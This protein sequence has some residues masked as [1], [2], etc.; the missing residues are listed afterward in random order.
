MIRKHNLMKAI[1][2][3]EYGSPNVLQ[4]KEVEK[5]TPG[6]DELLIKVHAVSVNRS[7]WEG[8]IGKPLYA[9]MGGLR[10]PGN[11][12]L[13]SDVAGHVE[14]VGKNNREFQPGDEVFGEMEGYHSGFAEYV[15][16]RGKAWALKPVSMTFEQASAIPQAGVIALQGIRDKGQ[17]QPGQ[18]VLINGAGGG[19]GTF[20]IQLAKLYGAEV[21]GVDN[22]GKLD[23]MRSLGTDHVIDY[24]QEN[25]TRNGKQYDFILDLIAYR[26]AFAYARAL[27]P[28]GSYYA[29]G[30]SVVTFLQ[31]LLF[32]PWIRRTS[33]KKVRLLVVQRN[34]KDLESVAELCEAGKIVPAIDRRYPLSEVPEALRYLGENQAKGKVVITVE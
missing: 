25:F 17:L 1:L 8:L 15:C 22:T 27:K 19:A 21:T 26:S 18:K 34:R 3:H 10:K 31:F 5:P 4:L 20:A 16:T 33:G 24:T 6:N 29:V 14:M 9:R 7:D 11:P 13:G 32:G 2:Y 23:F 28:N 12:I 30:G